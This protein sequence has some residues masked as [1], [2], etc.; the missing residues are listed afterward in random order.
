MVGS[1]VVGTVG[2]PGTVGSAGSG[3]GSETCLVRAVVLLRASLA[4]VRSCV[5]TAVASVGMK[6]RAVSVSVG[7]DLAVRFFAQRP[8]ALRAY[9][10]L[11]FFLAV[12]A[13]DQEGWLAALAASASTARARARQT[14][15]QVERTRILLDPRQ[16]SHHGARRSTKWTIVPAVGCCR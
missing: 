9:P 15:R 14:A 4:P 8:R 10:R 7:C 6:G 1:P 11:H 16:A 12:A 3:I 13:G 5:R 2:S